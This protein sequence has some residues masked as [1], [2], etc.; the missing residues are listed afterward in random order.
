[1]DERLAIIGGSKA[2][3]LLQTGA[4]KGERLGGRETPFGESWLTQP[5]AKWSSCRGTARPDM[6]ARHRG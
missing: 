5:V 3:E 1:M 6:P 2:Y 4:L